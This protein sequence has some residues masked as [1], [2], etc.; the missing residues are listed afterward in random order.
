MGTED[1]SWPSARFEVATVDS[2]RLW[3]EVRQELLCGKSLPKIARERGYPVLRFCQW[4]G[5][6]EGRARQFEA[7]LPV[8]AQVYISETVEIADAERRHE[9]DVG[10]GG[11]DPVARDALRVKTRFTAA[12]K[13]V[14]GRWGKQL[15]VNASVA[16]EVQVVNYADVVQVV[17]GVVPA[18]EVVEIADAELIEQDEH[19]L[20]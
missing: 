20:I 5:E 16:M 4:V 17:P 13:L 3:G 14:P 1:N 10:G 9:E 15:N 11:Y 7:L 12:E 8:F 2:E 18:A 19:G 6:D